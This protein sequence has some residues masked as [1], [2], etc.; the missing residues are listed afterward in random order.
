MCTELPQIPYNGNV[1]VSLGL[2]KAAIVAGPRR[3]IVVPHH[4]GFLPDF[5]S[6]L[7]A[8]LWAQQFSHANLERFCIFGVANA[9]LDMKL[10]FLEL[11]LA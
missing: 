9:K 10:V 6:V 1:N 5:C 2:S 11:L 7:A 4:G 8:V 3:D